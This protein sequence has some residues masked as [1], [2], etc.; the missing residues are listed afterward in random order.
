MNADDHN[1]PVK[2]RQSPVEKKA[3][4][5]KIQGVAVIC[6]HILRC[7]PQRTANGCAAQLAKIEKGIATLKRQQQS[8]REQMLAP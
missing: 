1:L 4:R 7:F 2:S 5:S 8:I 6:F 3:F